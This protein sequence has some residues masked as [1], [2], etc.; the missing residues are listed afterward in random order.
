MWG[1]HGFRDSLD[2]FSTCLD[3]DVTHEARIG[4]G[5]DKSNS[6]DHD[7]GDARPVPNGCSAVPFESERGPVSRYAAMAG[8]LRLVAPLEF[9]GPRTNGL[10]RPADCRRLRILCPE[11]QTVTFRSWYVDDVDHG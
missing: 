10:M 8:R 5:V 11:P 9:V 3:E 6:S 7:D 2:I 1:G 4:D